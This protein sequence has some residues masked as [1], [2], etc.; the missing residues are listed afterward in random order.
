VRF[1]F[2]VVFGSIIL[3]GAI[4]CWPFEAAFAILVLG[5]LK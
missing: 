2:N 4:A 3:L 1:Y 5:L